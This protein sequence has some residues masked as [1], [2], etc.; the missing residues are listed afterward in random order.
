M[1]NFLFVHV[2]RRGSRG[3]IVPD[4]A[5]FLCISMLARAVGPNIEVEIRPVLDQIFALGLS[6]ELT[7][8]LKVLAREIPS[9]QKDIQ[10]LLLFYLVYYYYCHCTDG[11]LKMLYMILLHQ[12]FKHPGAPKIA[13]AASTGPVEAA[14]A[15]LAIII[16]IIITGIPITC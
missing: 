2:S 9:L 12:Q 11:L 6:L 15:I 4:P 8:A 14:G 13:P 7:N 10:G 3:I 1:Y 5:V 16:I